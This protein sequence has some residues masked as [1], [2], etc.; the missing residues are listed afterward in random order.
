[1]GISAAVGHASRSPIEHPK[2]RCQVNL[3]KATLRPRSQ[4]LAPH[5]ALYLAQ[6]SLER[7]HHEGLLDTGG[8]LVRAACLGGYYS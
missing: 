2:V 8:L 6:S 7:L 5:E 3:Q 4:E 1:M